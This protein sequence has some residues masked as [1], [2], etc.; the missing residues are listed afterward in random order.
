MATPH[1][2]ALHLDLR[3]LHAVYLVL[4]TSAETREVRRFQTYQGSDTLGRVEFEQMLDAMRHGGTPFFSHPGNLAAIRRF[5]AAWRNERQ[6]VPP[7]LLIRQFQADVSHG[8]LAVFRFPSDPHRSML[9]GDAGSGILPG[10]GPVSGWSGGQK[11]VAMFEAIPECLGEASRAEFRAFLTPQNLAVMALFFGGIAVV[12]AVPGAD[13]IVD[14]MIV[15]LA[16][17]QFGWAGLIAGKDLVEAV[18]KAGH[19]RTGEEIKLAAKLAAAAL[20]SLGLLVLLREIIERV[21]EVKPKAPETEDEPVRPPPRRVAKAATGRSGRGGAAEPSSPKPLPRALPMR[22]PLYRSDLDEQWFDPK[23]GD[24]RWPPNDGFDGPAVRTELQPGQTIDR[25]SGFSGEDDAGSFLSPAG[26]P[27]GD[28]ALPYDPATQQHA[29]YEVLKPIP[30][31][32]G[33]A[34]GWFGEPGGGVQYK[35]D[36]SVGDLVRGGYLQQ[37][38]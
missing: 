13:A 29:V 17:W 19:A 38:R 12:Q 9:R 37:V 35:T 22:R 25:Y 33:R 16:W 23:T 26:T 31:T 5:Y 30:V 11:V 21:H 15:G 6:E 18:I 2:Q 20:V 10:R 8:A 4:P 27:F 14:G 3:S 34:A 7:E 36:M 24:L 1:P 32:S 28:R